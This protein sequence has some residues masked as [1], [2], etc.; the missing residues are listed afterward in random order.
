MAA[1]QQDTTI[2]G[3]TTDEQLSTV[4]TL[5]RAV[6][7]EG[8]I[9]EVGCFRGR[10]S[11]HI[12]EHKHDSVMLT[13]IDPFP[14]VPTTEQGVSYTKMDWINNT[15]GHNNV[16]MVRGLSPLNIAFLQFEKSPDLVIL[17]LNDVLD[18]L[19]FWNIHLRVGG[20]IVVHTYN[21]GGIFPKIEETVIAYANSH[22][23]LVD[24]MHYS[25]ILTKVK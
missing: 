1:K 19:D 17:D 3:T 24:N 22:D 14:D 23:F 5:T 21:V 16:N 20:S 11:V 2:L 10:Q 13:C 12:A 25:V 7:D 9:V 6:P 15:K 4:A 18:S 8:W